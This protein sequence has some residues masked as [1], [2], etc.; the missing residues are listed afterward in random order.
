ML[1]GLCTWVEGPGLEAATAA[2]LTLLR[3]AAAGPSA[4]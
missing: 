4:V 3:L 2:V 1:Q